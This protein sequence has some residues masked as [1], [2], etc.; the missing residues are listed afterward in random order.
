[1]T[2]ADEPRVQQ[3][4]FEELLEKDG[5]LVYTNVGCSM[6]PLL[7]Q[8]RDIIEIRK[9]GPERCKKYDVALYK[10]GE[11]YILHRVLKVLPDGYL[12]AGDHNTF[13]ER[14]VT[15]KMILGVMTRVIRNGKDICMDNPPVPPLRP[16]VV[17][18]LAPA[19]ADPAWNVDNSRCF[20][21]GEKKAVS[22]Q[23]DGKVINSF[24]LR[25]FLDISF[26]SGIINNE[27]RTT[28]AVA[29]QT[30][31]VKCGLWPH[32]TVTLQSGGCSF[33]FAFSG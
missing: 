24:L 11:K 26:I 9:K 25:F 13:V 23:R 10:R 12:I 32:P 17:R 30:C 8:R 6:M 3:V 22:P 27:E 15:D 19:Y 29:P 28:H 4:S 14:D 18:L 21:R 20:R 7:R 2:I 16:P 5:V 1:M 31:I 33:C